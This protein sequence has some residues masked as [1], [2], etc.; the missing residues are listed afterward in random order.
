[1]QVLVV[2]ERRRIGDEHQWAQLAGGFPEF[3]QP[4]EAEVSP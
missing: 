3:D 1:M 4:L 2:P